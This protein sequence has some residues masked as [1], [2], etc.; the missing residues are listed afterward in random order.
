MQDIP[1]DGVG[2][3]VAARADAPDGLLSFDLLNVR[4]KG[5]LGEVIN[6]F[7][8]LPLGLFGQGGQDLE[9]LAVDFWSLVE[10]KFTDT[11]LF[12]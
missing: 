2:D 4:R 1:L 8:D 9:G 5:L 11:D 10:S 3:A 7:G 6:A 12:V